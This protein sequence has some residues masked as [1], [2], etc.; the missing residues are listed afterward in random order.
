M[1]SINFNYYFPKDFFLK[2]V[3]EP[4]QAI[5]LS[6]VLGCSNA[7]IEGDPNKGEPDIYINGKWFELT[8]A[9]D[10]DNSI[11]YINSI[12]TNNLSTNQLESVSIDCIKDACTKKSQKRY[13]CSKKSLNVLLTIPI[14]HWTWIAYSNTPELVPKTKFDELL[15]FIKMNYI[16][17]GIFDDVFI[18]MPGF[19]YDWLIFS[20]LTGKLTKHIKLNDSEISSSQYPYVVKQ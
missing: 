18:T 9:S 16:D 10:S 4:I 17:N 1:K 14:Y 7:Y 19:C 8:L 12:R 2:K 3:N 13:S 15:C 6:K 20:S 5:F 11:N